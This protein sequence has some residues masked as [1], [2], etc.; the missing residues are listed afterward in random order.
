[1]RARRTTAKPASPRAGWRAARP[2]LSAR[3][4]HLMSAERT[5]QNCVASGGL[6][7]QPEA[8]LLSGLLARARKVE[9]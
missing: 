1:M 6:H 4:T 3:S 8:R 2:G 5:C 7:P 9:G